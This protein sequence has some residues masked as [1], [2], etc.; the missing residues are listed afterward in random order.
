MNARERFLATMRFAPVDR[1]LNWEMGYWAGTLD[2]WHSEGL[3][4]HPQGPQGLVPGAGVKGEGFP[5]RRG[6][7]LD[8]AVHAHFGLDKGIEK[9]D[10]EWGIWPPFP[11]EV[12]WE[13]EETVKQR[14]GDGTVVLVRK[15]SSSLP[16]PLEWPV[17]DRASWEQLKSER[18]RIDSSGRFSP[19][20]PQQVAAYKNRD[21]PLVI[22]GPFLGA[23]S[24]LRTLF[25]FEQM[26]FAFFDDPQ[27]VHDVLGHL[28]ELW[29]AL[30]EETLSQTDVDYAYFWEDMSYKSGSM[31]SPRIFREFL[32]PV[33]KRINA[34]FRAH[35][36]D[37]VLLD[38]DGSVWDLIPLFLESG[39]TGLYPFEVRAGMDVAEVRAKY[40]RLQMMGGIDKTALELGPAAIDA[41]LRRVAPVVKSGGYIPG[42]D[43]YVHPGVP[44]EYFHYY[45]H[46]LE[47]IL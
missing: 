12:L 21:W 37:I 39:V 18:L 36:L 8:H 7:P 38:T 22:G 15:D 6:E 46:A 19:E 31:V 10:G 40:P 4:R 30:F 43:H 11:T 28:T 34:F 47:R 29:L 26:M 20:W 33:Y 35:G 42:V 32:M 13:D 45:R 5:W 2:R 1:V 25:G 16:H 9:I 27:L 23:F 14:A 24:S 17:K 44:W 41:E 3:P